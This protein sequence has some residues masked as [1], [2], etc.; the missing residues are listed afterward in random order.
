MAWRRTGNKPLSDPMV[1]NLLEHIYVTR[2]QWVNQAEGLLQMDLTHLIYSLSHGTFARLAFRCV[3]LW[4]GIDGCYPY[5]SGSLHS[6]KNHIILPMFAILKNMENGTYE[7]T[8]ITSNITERHEACAYS[9]G[10]T[11]VLFYRCNFISW[12]KCK[13]CNLNM[14]SGW[15]WKPRSKWSN[16]IQLLRHE[17]KNRYHL[18]SQ[19]LPCN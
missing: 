14:N 3:S 13:L 19:Q 10:I 11:V 6:K 1:I 17:G 12:Y 4:F 16:E 15:V 18:Y 9:M 2:P 7:S 5:P 8:N